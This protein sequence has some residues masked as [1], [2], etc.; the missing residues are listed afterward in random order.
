MILTKLINKFFNCLNKC[1][2][3]RLTFHY[4]YLKHKSYYYS[5]VV[6]PSVSESKIGIVIQGPIQEK[7]SLTLETLLLYKQIYP[8][9]YIVLSTWDD[10]EP[11]IVSAIRDNGI[12][13]L[14][15]TKPDK[16]GAH[17]VNLQIIST[18]NGIEAAREKGCV[19][20]LKTRTDMR[21]T[22]YTS[23][24]AL[25]KLL[26]MFPSNKKSL[27]T[28]RIIEVGATACRF[29]PWSLCDLFQFGYTKDLL[30][31]WSVEL[32]ARD[33]TASDF[34][35]IPRTPREVSEH[36]VA[37]IYL[38]RR[39]AG[40]LGYRVEHIPLDYYEF[41][42]G[43]IILIDKEMLDLAWFKYD[44]FECSWVGDPVYGKN[45]TL[46]RIHF[47]EWL[48]IY[49]GHKVNMKNLNSFL[50]IYER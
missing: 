23:L 31:F 11:T 46:S 28:G 21:F 45:Q 3:V 26:T 4:R 20:I 6:E 42:R 27:S 17:N 25:L 9:S 2:D 8:S 49:S 32:D 40:K 44:S 16:N 15:S 22:R 29:R 48:L 37:E 34:F 5:R 1:L 36:D 50:D 47:F 41:I 19:Y 10:A 35:S 14:L 24:S 43:E 30:A 7:G 38:H 12:D 13:V 33:S 18:L 39:Y